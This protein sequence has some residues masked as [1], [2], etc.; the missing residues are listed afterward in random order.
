MDDAVRRLGLG[1]SDAQPSTL[2]RHRSSVLGGAWL[3]SGPSG[4]ASPRGRVDWKRRSKTNLSPALLGSFAEGLDEAKASEALFELPA[5]GTAGATVALEAGSTTTRVELLLL[6][7]VSALVNLVLLVVSELAD[8]V[9]LVL[10]VIAEGAIFGRRKR[11]RVHGGWWWCTRG[12]FQ[13]AVADRVVGLVSAATGAVVEHAQCGKLSSFEVVDHGS[14]EASPAARAVGRP[15]RVEDHLASNVATKGN[16]LAR[17]SGGP[18]LLVLLRSSDGVRRSR[19]SG[20]VEAGGAAVGRVLRRIELVA[21]SGGLRRVEIDA[22]VVA[23]V[24]PSE[25]NP[26][27]VGI[28]ASDPTRR[29]ALGG[30]LHGHGILCKGV[31][32][33]FESFGLTLFHA[34]EEL[35]LC[36]DFFGGHEPELAPK[37]AEVGTAGRVDI[38]TVHV[39]EVVFDVLGQDTPERGLQGIEGRNGDGIVECVQ[40]FRHNGMQ[41]RAQASERVLQRRI[42]LGIGRMT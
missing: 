28:G 13:R 10:F 14:Q 22:D 17:A 38:L 19:G 16:H 42:G 27:R 31:I 12:I 20:R 35:P 30:S 2:V 24:I 29:A 25:W 23:R 15:A 8:A 39:E 9:A 36:N 6:V 26:G 33:D 1:H 41:S 5:T 7:R 11:R 37:G 21:G 3:G 40:G 18:M 4:R 32:D 34:T